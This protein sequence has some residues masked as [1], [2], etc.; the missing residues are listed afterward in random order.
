M[1]HMDF[2]FIYTVVVQFFKIN[3]TIKKY[4]LNFKMI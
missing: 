3:K 4:D 1:I 2:R